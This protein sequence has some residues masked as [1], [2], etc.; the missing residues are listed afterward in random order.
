MGIRPEELAALRDKD[1]QEA[2]LTKRP[3]RKTVRKTVGNDAPGNGKKA[4]KDPSL[5]PPKAA[6]LRG[7]GQ[8]DYARRI[9]GLGVSDQTAGWLANIGWFHVYADNEPLQGLLEKLSKKF[10]LK[11]KLDGMEALDAL[12]RLGWPRRKAESVVSAATVEHGG[13]A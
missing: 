10:S 7:Q 3:E 8:D 4:V 1:L 12:L 5:R 9:L 11:R 6:K 13:E 2:S